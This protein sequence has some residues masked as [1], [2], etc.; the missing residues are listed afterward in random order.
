MNGI[1]AV[2]KSIISLISEAVAQAQGT[3]KLPAVSVPPILIEHPQNSQHGDYASGLPLKMARATGMKPLDIAG[4]IAGF[5][6]AVPEIKSVTVAPP[7]FLNFTLSDAW[8]TEQVENVI[9]SGECYGNI[10]QGNGKKVQIEY[11]S[12][13]P[14]GP[15][16]VGHGRGAVLGSSLAL[17]LR[18]AGFDVQQE[19]Y[20]NDAGNQ[21]MSF[22][23]SLYARYLQ[24]LGIDAEMPAEG[25]FGH[26]MIDL[27]RDI[28]QEEGDRFHEMPKDE[29]V[30]Q[31]G[32]VGLRKMLDLIRT[33]LNRLGVTFDRWFSE[34]SLYDSGEFAG[35]LEMLKKS[36]YVAEKEGAVWFTSTALGESKDNV[37]IRTDGTPTYFAS[38]IAYHYDKFVRRGFDMVINIWG[39]DHQGHVSRMKAVL[40]ALGVDP[41]RLDVIISQLVTLRRGEEL[42]RL[43]KRTGEIITL[44]EVLDEVGSDACRFNFL[45]RS[46]DSQM[47]FD[48]ELAKK[49]SA[50]NPVYYVQYAHAR[51]CSIISLARDKEIDYADGDVT[52][53]VEPAELEL[54]R[55]M[56]LLPEVIAQVAD[57]FSPHHLAYYAQVLANA[58]HLFYKD[59]RVVSADLCLSKARLK[60]AVA[61][62]TVLAR[63]LHLMGM[64]APECM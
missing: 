29:A 12:A 44:S 43:S 22:K 59:C 56:L 5:I 14:T 50:E 30:E 8:I 25:Y 31:L 23:R 15:I 62:R 32:I 27:A 46:A 60:L 48:L 51:I 38:D 49:Q 57:S 47:D 20:V 6:P 34:Q 40:Q 41:A 64:S 4:I 63:T 26:Y 19:Y 2:K 24:Q 55:K 42:V 13:N 11:V 3:G 1:L 54:L 10:D 36:G 28:L 9:A 58:F 16:H 52:K 18:A 7:G 37:I 21:V 17:A 45:S 39:A 53:L 35:V 61:A 33:D